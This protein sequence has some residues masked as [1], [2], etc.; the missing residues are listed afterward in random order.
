MGRRKG[1]QVAA[2]G[3]QLLNY[4]SLKGGEVQPHQQRWEQL[5]QKA[6]SFLEAR[7]GCCLWSTTV[8]ISWELLPKKTKSSMVAK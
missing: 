1:N 3:Q 7:I 6:L 5:K 8:S 4:T 2:S